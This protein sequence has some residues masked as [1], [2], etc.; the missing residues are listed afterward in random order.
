M[1]LLPFSYSFTLRRRA[2]APAPSAVPR[3]ASETFSTGK[4][5]AGAMVVC[6]RLQPERCGLVR[7]TYVWYSRSRP[8]LGHYW[9]LKPQARLR[10]PFLYMLARRANRAAGLLVHATAATTAALRTRRP[11]RPWRWRAQTPSTVQRWALYGHVAVP[12][13]HHTAPSLCTLMRTARAQ[14]V[15]LTAGTVYYLPGARHAVTAARMSS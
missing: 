15:H 7:Q 12:A 5:P 6:C 10:Q 2:R 8:G 14:Y 9:S 11:P 1:Q 4:A 13:V 3:C